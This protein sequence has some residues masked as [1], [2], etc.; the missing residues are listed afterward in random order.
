MIN[1]KQGVFI[2]GR[3][4]GMSSR[5]D[6]GNVYHDLAVDR[7]FKDEYEKDRAETFRVAV[8]SGA[9]RRVKDVVKD[10]DNSLVIVHVAPF[11]QAGRRGPWIRWALLEGADGITIAQ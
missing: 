6:N 3:L 4:V 9:V 10:A 7:E 11:P 1:G 5:E 8:P 2:T